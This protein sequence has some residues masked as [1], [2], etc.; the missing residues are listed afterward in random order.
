LEHNAYK[1]SARYYDIFVEPFNKILRKI[2]YK[3]HPG[4]KGLRVLEVGCGTATNLLRYRD[5]G[6]LVFG[7]DLSPWMLAEARRKFD[8]EG[9]FIRADAGFLPVRPDSFD[10]SIAMLTLHEM[11][12]DTRRRVLDEMVRVT[13]EGGHLLL[14]DFHPGP[15][16]FPKGWWY[17]AVILFFEVT[18]GGE[19]FR[20]YRNFIR[21]RGLEPLLEGREVVIEKRRIVGHGTMGLYLLRKHKLE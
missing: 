12:P 19:H 20:N 11:S 8:S 4:E 2:A 1:N 18:A 14:V 3:M 17:K 7:A 6:G 21:N 15:I 5:A 10:V 9:Q 13:R 16:R